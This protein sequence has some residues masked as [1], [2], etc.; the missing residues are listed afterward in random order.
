VSAKRE[1]KP[2]FA[3]DGAQP[4]AGPDSSS[5][6]TGAASSAT[7]GAAGSAVVAGIVAVAVEPADDDGSISKDV[8]CF[9]A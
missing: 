8:S 1:K 3:S 6:D 7:A 2:S 4:F 5:A 9:T